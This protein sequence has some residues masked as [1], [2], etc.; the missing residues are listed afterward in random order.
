MKLTSM[1]RPNRETPGPKLPEAPPLAAA[2][3]GEA[4]LAVG[5]PETNQAKLGE[6]WGLCYHI[7][8]YRDMYICV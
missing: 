8:V 1:S 7:Y 4:L 2:I 6:A 3:P 5:V